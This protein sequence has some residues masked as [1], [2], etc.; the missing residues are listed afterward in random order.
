MAKS[1]QKLKAGQLRRQGKSI[2]EIAGLLDASRST[3]SIWCRDIKLTPRQIRLLNEKMIAGGHKGRLKGAAIQKERKREKIERYLI[4]GKK[5]IGLLSVREFL[6]AG[7]CLYWGEGN[8]KKPGVRFF[9]SDPEM[10]KFILRWFKEMFGIEN[11]RYIIYIMINQIHKGRINDVKRYWKN[12]LGLPNNCFRKPTLI[13]A[14]SKKVYENFKQH[15][16]TLNIRISKSTD[17]YYRILGLI[18]GLSS[19]GVAQW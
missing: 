14:K 7:L 2:K 18:K 8:R 9:N 16:G 1:K 5:E 4:A 12:A 11:E 3:I 10:I 13:K 6:I 15:Y 19:G 17:L